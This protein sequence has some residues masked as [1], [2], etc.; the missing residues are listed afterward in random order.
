MV[1]LM[2]SLMQGVDRLTL[3]FSQLVIASLA[4]SLITTLEAAVKWP[5]SVTW[6]SG[7]FFGVALVRSVSMWWVLRIHASHL[8]DIE[9]TLA[10]YRG[11]GNSPLA[12]VCSID[13]PWWDR[14]AVSISLGH[15]LQYEPGGREPTAAVSSHR[16]TTTAILLVLQSPRPSPKRSL[17]VVYEAQHRG[18]LCRTRLMCMQILEKYMAGRYSTDHPEEPLDCSLPQY[19]CSPAEKQLLRT[20]MNAATSAGMALGLQGT[21]TGLLGT[22]S[23]LPTEVFAYSHLHPLSISVCS[24]QLCCDLSSLANLFINCL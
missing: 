3:V 6:V 17:H 11:C 13:L 20:C 21:T 18:G 10:A 8:D 9:A 7:A 16:L 19:S 12:E 5:E 1:F 15:L 24:S 14:F 2:H 4:V 23:P 22:G